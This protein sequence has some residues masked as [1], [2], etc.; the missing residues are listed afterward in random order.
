M[1]ITAAEREKSTDGLMAGNP[2]NMEASACWRSSVHHLS[3]LALV[4]R[5]MNNPGCP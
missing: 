2:P 5:L 3:L 1:S 4:Q